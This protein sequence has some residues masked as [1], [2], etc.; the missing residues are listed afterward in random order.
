MFARITCT[1]KE[2]IS[3]AAIAFVWPILPGRQEAWRRF[4]QVLLG[5]RLCEYEESRQRLG[6]TKELIWLAQTLQGDMAIM[7]L[8]AE[9]PERV[10][11]QLAASELPFDRWFGGQLLELHGLDVTQLPSGSLSELV[12]AW[13]ASL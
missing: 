6:V 12:F 10:T 9:H 1:E 2:G 11:P 8:E 7:Y 4:C 3:V 5:S 13:Q